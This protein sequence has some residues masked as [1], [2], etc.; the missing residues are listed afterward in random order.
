MIAFSN[1]IKSSLVSLSTHRSMSSRVAVCQML[2]K[3]DLEENFQQVADLVAK[4][5]EQRAQ[6][7]CIVT[8]G[9]PLLNPPHFQFVFLPECCDF[10]GKNRQETLALSES[11]TPGKLL[12]RYC[13][14]ARRHG[15]WLS[16]G[17]LH[18]LITGSDKIHNSHVV[19]NER[20]EI[21]G[22]YRKLHLFDVDTPEFKF[23]ES[24]VVSA[25]DRIVPPIDTPIGRLGLQ[26][27]REI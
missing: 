3:N 11:L 18:E 10:V 12:S 19:I 26:I 9:V 5:K 27:V 15:L 25:G 24:Q 20:G 2:A 6:V 22:K 8:H 23:R 21:C 7:S 16:L 14:L 17:G 1:F 4:A 13:D